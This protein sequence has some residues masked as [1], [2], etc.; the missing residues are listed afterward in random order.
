MTALS[1]PRNT[2]KRDGVMLSLPVAAA[3]LLYTGALVAVNSTGYATPGA[4]ATGLRGLGRVEREVDNSTGSAGDISV[5]ILTGVFRWENSAD[6]DEITLADIG[7]VAWIVDDQTVAKTSASAT[8]SPSGLIV[9]VDSLGVWVD[10]RPFH[11]AS[12]SGAALGANNLSDLA[13]AATAR[14]NLGVFLAHM[15]DPVIAAP[16]AEA[17]NAINVAIQLK[18]IGGA[19]LAA[20]GAVFA[21]LSDDASGDSVVGTAPDGG[22]AIGTDGLLIP[23][24]AGKAAQLISESDGDIDVTITHAAGAKTVYL[25]LISPRGKLIASNAITFA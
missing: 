17:G 14:G 13:N 9:E 3:K 22:W 20:R 23:I 12:T 18:T 24:V 10:S 8:R 25:I 11:A 21:Y 4:T 15:G 6:A 19:D 7:Q 16:G 1:A 5:D 2:A